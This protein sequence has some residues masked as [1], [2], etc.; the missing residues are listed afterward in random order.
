MLDIKWIRENPEVFDAAMQK[1]NNSTR[2]EIILKIDEEKRQKIS[3]IQE[4]QSQRNKIAKDIAEAK[5]SGSS[6]DAL[7]EQSKEVNKNLSAA[8]NDSS[9]DEKLNEILSI[10][11]NIPDNEVP[12]GKDENDNIEVEKFGAIKEFNFEPK[13]HDEIG[14]NL[15]ML[16]F[17][18]SALISG[19]RFST[20]SGGLA[21]L[22]RA[23]SNFMLDVA[24]EFGYQEISP[25]NLV[26]SEA[27]YGSGQL[28][29]FA[30]DA[31]V[32]EDGYWLIP[33]AEVSLVNLVAKN[34]LSEDKLPLRFTA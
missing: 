2:A 25:P 34:I 21:K 1:R 23:L 7:L 13:S 5:K 31:F 15:K 20:L 6:A 32:T 30:E 26:K 28:P 4:L 9:L 19:A 11:P 12:V 17:E 27:M 18:Q 24:T 3:L 29:K 10:T 33:T 8:E 22:E 14:E 16:D